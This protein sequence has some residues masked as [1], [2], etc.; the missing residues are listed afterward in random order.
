MSNELIVKRGGSAHYFI[1]MAILIVFGA[2][3]AV[4]KIQPPYLYYVFIIVGAVSYTH[5]DVY[6]RQESYKVAKSCC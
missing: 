1:Y 6:K 2:I 4:L 3:N 5:L